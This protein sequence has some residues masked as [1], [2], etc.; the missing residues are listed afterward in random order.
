MMRL[1]ALHPLF[2]EHTGALHIGCLANQSPM[3]S[4]AG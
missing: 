4:L 3:R 1:A 2:I